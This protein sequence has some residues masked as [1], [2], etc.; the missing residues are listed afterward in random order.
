MGRSRSNS[1]P[2]EESIAESDIPVKATAA[3]RAYAMKGMPF[4][5]DQVM[6]A[7]KMGG[8]DLKDD[9][10]LCTCNFWIS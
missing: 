5:R 1:G 8:E 4:N 3:G 9:E 7:L 10:S 2:G 6:K